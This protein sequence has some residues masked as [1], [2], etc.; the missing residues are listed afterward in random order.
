MEIGHE[1]FVAELDRLKKFAKNGV[2]YWMGRDI[3]ATLGYSNWQNF[4]MVIRKAEEACANTGVD[5]AKHFIETS[6]VIEAGKGAQIERAD[7][8]LGRYACYLIAMNGDSS[9]QEISYAQAYFAHQARRQ[10]LQDQLS[11]DERR[12]FLRDRVKAANKSL[13]SAAKKAGV[14]RFPIFHDEGYKGLYG[15]L[16]QADIKRKKGIPEKDA[17][18][19]CIGR[20][21][22]AANEFRITQTE[23]KL[24][25]EKIAT[26]IEAFRTH[27]EVGVE[28]RQT[29]KKLGGT[30][31]EN[32][33]AEEPIKKLLAA[34]RKE[35]KV[36]S[37]KS[38][39]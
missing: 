2:E 16:G 35:L 8:I 37:K 23:Q 33:P 31:P 22:L 15:G 18:L 24:A 19:D 20:A 14:Q 17:L 29:M 7:W 3:Q 1:T 11:P 34:K 27:H 28:V 4:E 39:N 32:L 25:R 26:E 30:L 10:E 21:E 5:S 12:L 13:S 6:R 9:K 38:G 36:A